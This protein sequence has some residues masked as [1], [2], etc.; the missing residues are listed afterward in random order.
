MAHPVVV[1][2]ATLRQFAQSFAGV[3]SLPQWKYFVIVLLGLLHCEAARTLSGMLRPVAVT[4]TVSGLSRFLKRAPWSVADLTAARTARFKAQVAAEVAQAHASQRAER[5]RRRGRPC[6]TV[7]TGFLIQDDSTH[8]K[9]YAEAMEGQGWHNATT[10]R[11]SMP[12]HSLFQSVYCL[13][14]RE[15]PLT[16][17]RY[18]QQSV[19]EQEG[20]PFLSKVDLA[21]RAI[22]TFEPP[23]DTQTHVLVDSWYVNQAVWRATRQRNWDLTGGLKSNRQVR[24]TLPGGQRVW[25]KVTAYAA[26][27]TADAFQPVI[28]PNQEGG[29]QVYGH[30]LRTR[31]KKLGACQLL[32]V[33]FTPDAPVSQYRYWVTSRLDDILAEVVAAV[34]TRWTIETLFA[35]RKELMGSDQYQIRSAQAI[36]RFWALALCLYQYL[37]EQRARLRNERQ[38]L[39]TLG[40]ARTW[41]RQRHA[42]LLLDWLAPQFATGATP[43]QVR[44]RLK[45]ALA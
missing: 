11:K 42:D 25:L 27:L 13:L 6:E 9:R 17:E 4:A 1:Q 38:Q 19:C 3:F 16:P 41:V 37:D 39:V 32:V 12:G 34:A 18:R 35:D 36:V 31:V 33:K 28:W 29:Q 22:Q 24:Q 2:D 23:P 44:I 15:L 7:V 14:G 20:V 40:E 5:P 8:V 26:D 45:P 30:L 21:V 43:A 10:E